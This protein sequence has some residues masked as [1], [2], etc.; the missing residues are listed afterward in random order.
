V[1]GVVLRGAGPLDLWPNVLAL[2]LMS[3]ALI[4]LSVRQFRK[5]AL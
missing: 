1:R 3:V 4:V 5:V 2:A